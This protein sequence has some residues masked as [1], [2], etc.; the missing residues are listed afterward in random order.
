MRIEG[1]LRNELKVVRIS[2][3]KSQPPVVPLNPFPPPSRWQNPRFSGLETETPEAP[4][5]PPLHDQAQLKHSHRPKQAKQIK[6][7]L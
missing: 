1:E 6:F 5:A 7:A 3:A 2:R 4:S